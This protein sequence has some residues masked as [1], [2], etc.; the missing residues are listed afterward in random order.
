MKYLIAVG[1][2]IGLLSCSDK[3]ITI[4]T[5]DN[6]QKKVTY[7]VLKG[8]KDNPIDFEYKAYYDNGVLMKE[9][10]MENVKEEGEWK[11]YFDNGEVSSIGNFKD[12]IR[13]GKFIRYY[14]GGQI[15]QEGRYA[16]GEIRQSTFFYR[17]GIIKKEVLD[18]LLF[19]KDSPTIWTESQREKISARCNHVLQFDH[20]NSEMFCKCIVD[21]VSTYVEFNALDTLSDYDK[22]LIYQIFMKAGTCNELFY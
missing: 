18:P 11:Y 10:L 9:G 21:T 2:S 20:K 7:K 8:S 4:Q 22:S 17:N 1:L 14:E 6:G 13:S 3:E 12:G 16:N 15:E 19:I 5:Y